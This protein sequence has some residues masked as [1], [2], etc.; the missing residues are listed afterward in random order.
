MLALYQAEWC[1][2]SHRVRAR[3]TE[4][5][6]DYLVHQVPAERDARGVLIDVTGVETIPVL[7]L[8]DGTILAGEDAIGGYL[9][10]CCDDP[11]DAAAH[12]RK[13][14]ELHRRALEDECGCAPAALKEA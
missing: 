13:A 10:S 5:G 4:L 6:L 7:V 8:G 14:D 12:R 1:P 9:D 2:A 3:L 11:P